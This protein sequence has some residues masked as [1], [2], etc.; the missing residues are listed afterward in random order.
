MIKK[1]EETESLLKTYGGIARYRILQRRHHASSNT[2]IGYD[3]LEEVITLA[4]ELQ[5]DLIIINDSLRNKQIYSIENHIEKRKKKIEVWDRVDLILMIFSK[6]AKTAEA[7]LQLELAR[8]E[9]FG[10]RIYGMG[11]E[12]SRQAGG[13]G[14]R[15][16]GETNTEIMKRHL[17]SRKKM[18]K[19]KLEK[20]EKNRNSN[21]KRRKKNRF[22]CISIVGYTNAGKSHL[23]TA[24]TRRNVLVEDKLFATLDT[25]TT[26]LFLPRCRQS[27]L[28]SDTI[29][30][31]RDLPPQLIKAFKSTLIEAQEA[32][33]LLQV[34]D[35]SDPNFLSKI[36]FVEK[37]LFDIHAQDIP[38]IYIFNKSDLLDAVRIERFKEVIET[39]QGILISARKGVN[40]NIVKEAIEEKLYPKSLWEGSNS[41]WAYSDTIDSKRTLPS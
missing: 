35:I 31:I 9:H 10:P 32:D 14:T 5:A 15:G 30:F 12:M 41:S 20:L 36:K 34:I 37:I 18:I 33:L 24:L 16:I 39:Y 8:I 40:I 7:Q 22:R 26:R 19:A 23:F 1:M 28:L 21:L 38:M 2:F 29:G 4:E 3:K 25:T 17:A 6:H 13:I 27:V 11:I